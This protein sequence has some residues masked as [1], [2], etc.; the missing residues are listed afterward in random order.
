MKYG[1]KGT[2]NMKLQEGE[3]VELTEVLYVYQ[4]VKNLLSVSRLVSKG[5][6]MGATEEKIP[7]IKTDPT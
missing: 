5:S 7:S 3:M 6:T 1:L 2:V 4:S